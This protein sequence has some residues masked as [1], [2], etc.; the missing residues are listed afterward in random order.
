MS[1]TPFMIAT[2]LLAA[3][4]GTASAQGAGSGREACRGP[5]RRRCSRCEAGSPLPPAGARRR[6]TGCSGSGRRSGRRRR[7][8]SRRRAAE[9]DAVE[10]AGGVHEA[11]R[12]QLEVRHEVRA[13]AMG[14]GSPEM[15]AK[16]TVKFSKDLNGFF[17]R[18]DYEIKKQ[19]GFDM[20]MKG[21]F[22]I[23]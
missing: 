23:G 4:A 12:G 17:Y 16:S 6:Q 11:V 22:Y 18:G 9:A 19:K 7:S 13:G 3:A 8:R 1:K 10:G 2:V 14:P 21:T 15:T 5:R 20:P